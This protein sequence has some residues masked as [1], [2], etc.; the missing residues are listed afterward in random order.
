MK[1][2]NFKYLKILLPVL[3]IFFIGI[4][5][6]SNKRKKYIWQQWNKRRQPESIV[7]NINIEYVI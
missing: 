3:A 6:F 5:I 2:M 7:N 1:I 4:Y